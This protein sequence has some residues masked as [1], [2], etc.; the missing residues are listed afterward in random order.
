MRI[1]TFLFLC[2]PAFKSIVTMTIHEIHCSIALLN[3]RIRFPSL[4]W[5]SDVVKGCF[6][7]SILVDTNLQYSQQQTLYYGVITVTIFHP[8]FYSWNYIA[9]ILGRMFPRLSKYIFNGTQTPNLL[10]LHSHQ[11]IIRTKIYSYLFR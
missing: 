8:S 1:I 6:P 4:L 3:W 2:F 7:L 10:C 5:R 9:V 11:I